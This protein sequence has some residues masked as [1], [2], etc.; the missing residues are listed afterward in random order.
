[1]FA[2]SFAI[3]FSC[4]AFEMS[5][6]EGDVDLIPLTVAENSPAVDTTAHTSPISLDSPNAST[7]QTEDETVV[8]L[9]VTNASAVLPTAHHLPAVHTTAKSSTAASAASTA[10]A[11]PS[12]NEE[13]GCECRREV[14]CV[15]TSCKCMA[16]GRASTSACHRKKPNHSC[17]NHGKRLQI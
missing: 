17:Q 5:G 2:I 9:T 10:G 7:N 4:R 1:M 15:T 6:R 3:S 8:P 12:P 14:K 13:E 11:L 16:N